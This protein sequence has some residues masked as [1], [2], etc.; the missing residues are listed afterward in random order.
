MADAVIAAQKGEYDEAIKL[1]EA[2]QEDIDSVVSIGMRL[3][4]MHASSRSW[5]YRRRNSIVPSYN[6]AV[7]VHSTYIVHVILMGAPQTSRSKARRVPGCSPGPSVVCSSATAPTSLSWALLSKSLHLHLH[8]LC[9]LAH[10]DSIL[11]QGTNSIKE[12][13]TDADWKPMAPLLPGALW[14]AQVHRGFYLGLFGQ[15]KVDSG[16]Q[17]PF[18]VFSYHSRLQSIAH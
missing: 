5:H 13:I 10:H 16:V 12:W 15:Y 18:G 11:V 7:S 17:I 4:L 1:L 8:S 2:A 3:S 9:I 14:G 6:F